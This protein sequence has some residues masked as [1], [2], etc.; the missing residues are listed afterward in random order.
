[1]C[2]SDL[3]DADETAAGTD[4]ARPD[5]DGDG[6][7]DGADPDPLS[8]GSTTAR[9]PPAAAPGFGLGCSTTPGASGGAIALAV[10]FRRRRAPGTLPAP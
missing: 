7:F 6:A 9:R 10:W 8:A 2:S 3:D 1:V 4:P 5:T